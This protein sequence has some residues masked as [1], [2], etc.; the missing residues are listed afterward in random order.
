MVSHN[1]TRAEGPRARAGSRPRAPWCARAR[2]RTPP[3]ARAY[4]QHRACCA[5]ARARSRARARGQ[6]QCPCRSSLRTGL[7]RLSLKWPCASACCQRALLLLRWLEPPPPRRVAAASADPPPPSPPRLHVPSP[8]VRL[9]PACLPLTLR[10]SAPHRHV[11]VAGSK[12]RDE[13]HP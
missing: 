13:L 5:R 3:H 8:C 7:C 2:V 11:G 6:C 9:E 12:F 4:T 10:V 1:K